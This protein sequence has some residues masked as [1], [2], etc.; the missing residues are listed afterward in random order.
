MGIR[1]TLGL[2]VTFNSGW[3]YLY[4]G[5]SG[6][7]ILKGTLGGEGDGY[8]ILVG[9]LEVSICE[10]GTYLGKCARYLGMGVTGDFVWVD[11]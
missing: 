7:L 3:V 8:A 1:A 5:C 10:E 4:Y 9:L 2:D 6:H 11:A